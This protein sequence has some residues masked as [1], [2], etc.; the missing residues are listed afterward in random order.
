M[1]YEIYIKLFKE[2]HGGKFEEKRLI[3]LAHC[4]ANVERLGV[5]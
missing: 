3:C 2:T 5:R 1:S 4:Y